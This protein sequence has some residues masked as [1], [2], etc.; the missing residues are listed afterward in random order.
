VPGISDYSRCDAA[1]LRLAAFIKAGR[2]ISAM[3]VFGGMDAALQPA[4]EDDDQITARHQTNLLAAIAIGH[5]RVD[6][7]RARGRLGIQPGTLPEAAM[8]D[9][10]HVTV[11]GQ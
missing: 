10:V 8:T 3:I 2:M 7:P 1:W 11:F 4:G 9:V 5:D 6:V